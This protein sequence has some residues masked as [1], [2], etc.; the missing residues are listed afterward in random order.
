MEI[1]YTL[2]FCHR[3]NIRVSVLSSGLFVD[4]PV[5][6][7]YSAIDILIKNKANWILKKQKELKEK[8]EDYDSVGDINDKQLVLNTKRILKEK[9]TF[10]SQLCCVSYNR[11]SV[12][13]LSSRWGSCSSLGNLNF[14]QRL[15]LLP[16]DLF[17]YVV[18]HELC[19]LKELNHGRVFWRLVESVLPDWKKRRERLKR[20]SLI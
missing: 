17:D 11:V 3:K 1:V 8:L 7:K 9:L 2:K 19:H 4:A 18:V 12:K 16:A 5:G 14:N 6:T 13:K 20:Y 15:C 10:Y